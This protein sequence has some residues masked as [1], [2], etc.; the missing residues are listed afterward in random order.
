MIDVTMTATWR[1]E[2]VYRTLQS[3]YDN[4]FGDRMKNSMRLIVNIDPAGNKQDLS[5]EICYIARDFFK[6]FVAFCPNSPH[7]GEAVVRIWGKTDSELVFHLEEDWEMLYL[8]NFEDMMS[9]FIQE[10]LVHLRLSIFRSTH[11]CKNWKYFYE[12]NG[13]FFQCP[14]EYRGTVGWCGHPSLNRGDFLRF[15]AENMDPSVN[16]EK[17]IKG[18]HPKIGPVI[19][20]SVFGSFIL[21]ISPANVTDIGREW[22]TKHG[23]HKIGNQEWFT[24][25][26]KREE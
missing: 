10:K 16:P 15:C 20:D 17:Q 22:R 18:R 12:W 26:E 4:L 19:E 21:P 7:F 1:P 3:F 8:M 14:D 2:L 25:W 13:M 23:Y 24:N 6:D 11:N 5:D 9:C